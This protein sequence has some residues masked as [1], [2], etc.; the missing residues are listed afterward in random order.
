MLSRNS[1]SFGSPTGELTF[2]LKMNPG[3]ALGSL[4]I[5]ARIPGTQCIPAAQQRA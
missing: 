4:Q 2:R 5:I 1:G 3:V